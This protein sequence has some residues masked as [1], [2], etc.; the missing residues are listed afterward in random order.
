MKSEFQLLFIIQPVS[1]TGP[2]KNNTESDNQHRRQDQTFDFRICFHY[3]LL[4]L[5]VTSSVSL[6]SAGER[7]F[8]TEILSVGILKNFNKKYFSP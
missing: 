5:K 3:S 6:L 4:S 2:V 7:V 1:I 8:V